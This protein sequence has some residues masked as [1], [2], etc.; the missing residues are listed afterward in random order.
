MWKETYYIKECFEEGKF[1]E[2][3]KKLSDNLFIYYRL[4]LIPFRR[5]KFISKLNEKLNLLLLKTLILYLK[6]SRG[7]KKIIIWIFHPNLLTVADYIG[8]DYFLIYDCVDFFSTGTQKEKREVEKYERKILKRADLVVANSTVL[9]NYLKKMKIRKDIHLV[10]Q[11]FRYEHFKNPIK[12]V[13]KF[14]AK[15]PIIGYVG[16]INERI[17]YKLLYKLAK[18]NGRFS[19]ILWGPLLD[20]QKITLSQK[21]VMKKL[22]DLPNVVT[23]KSKNKKEIP[24]IIKQFDVAMIPYDIS[25]DFNKYCYPMKLFEYFYLGKPVLSTPIEELKRF[26]KLVKF[27]KTANDWEG[28]IKILLSRKWLKKYQKEQRILAEENSWGKKVASVSKLLT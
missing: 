10:P 12:N 5:F 28:H 9:Q 20:E 26:P 14:N 4:Y 7:V 22:F 19:F 21:E 16:G 18:R 27:G 13:Y 17:D 25:Q 1:P 2:L 3:V 6:F 15:K 8:R 24:R 11:G 23:G